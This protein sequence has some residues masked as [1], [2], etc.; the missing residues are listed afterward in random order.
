[1]LDGV[2]EAWYNKAGVRREMA[3]FAREIDLQPRPLGLESNPEKIWQWWEAR[4]TILPHFF[5]LICLLI[6]IPTSSCS[7]ERCFSLLKL[8]H[9]P[10]HHNSL[11]DIVQSRVMLAYNGRQGRE[12]KRTR[13]LIEAFNLRYAVALPVNGHGAA[14][15]DEEKDDGSNAF[16]SHED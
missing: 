14:V 6:L 1:M 16:T 12:R 15:A 10:Q 11:N 7:V 8:Y 5:N 9:G 4:K 13:P 2:P 3:T